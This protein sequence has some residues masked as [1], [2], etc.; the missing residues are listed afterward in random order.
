[1]LISSLAR[2]QSALDEIRFS[3]DHYEI[4]G[5]NPLG[6]KAY[7]VVAPF[8]GD[9]YGLEG[10][11]AASDALEQALNSAGY[12]FHRV[13]LPP[14]E[15]L[16]GTV[17]LEI[18]KFTIG[19]IKVTG[20][21]FYSEA[22][23]RR[24]IPS[25]K[26]ATAPNTK[27]LSKSVKLANIN[28]SKNVTVRFNEGQEPDTI[29][30]ELKVVDRDP[31]TYFVSVDNTGG[32]QS[33]AVRM[34]LGYQNGNL[35]DKD[36][37]LTV[38]YTTAPENA[39]AANQVGISY[40]IPFYTNASKLNFLLSNSESNSGTVADNSIVTGKG[41]VLG[42]TYSQ[43]FFGETELEQNW[44]VGFMYKLFDNENII[45]NTKVLSSPLDLSYGFVNRGQKSSLSGSITASV[46]IPSGDN[47]S[48]ADYAASRS[49]TNDA[50]PNWNIIRYQLAWDYAFTPS[51]LFHFD[52]AGQSSNDVL[53]SGELFG[54]GGASTLRGFEERSVNGEKGY[55]TRYELWMPAFY[56]IRSLIFID[57]AQVESNVTKAT[58][59]LSSTG[60]GLRWSWKQNLSVNFDYGKITQGGGQDTTINK[61][62][63]DKSHLSI[64]YRF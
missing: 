34:T 61:D 21:K 45:S 50:S 32:Y 36:H 56:G 4:I 12:S 60:F 47:S 57:Q 35:F 11:S 18:V 10:L 3:V 63:D 26:P 2:A 6:K 23:I 25:L 53:I 64:V 14:Q 55:R 59:D 29:D 13:N 22:N 27:E 38:T 54:V 8:L 24:S 52:F 62:D 9:Q 16:S 33:E 19:N 31:Q 48:D 43:S 1:M 37:A 20:N 44:S 40:Q 15:L 51:W 30:A 17:I 49:D 41:S 58:Y 7:Q 5:D 42:V 39:D 28:G 46:N